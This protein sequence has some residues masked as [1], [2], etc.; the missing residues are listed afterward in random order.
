MSLLSFILSASLINSP[1]ITNIQKIFSSPPNDCMHMSELLQDKLKE[2]N[3]KSKS[4]LSNDCM[5]TVSENSEKKSEKN[6][7]TVFANNSYVV[8]TPHLIITIILDPSEDNNHEISYVVMN[9]SPN[10]KLDP[11]KE[12]NDLKGNCFAT[13]HELQCIMKTNTFSVSISETFNGVG[14]SM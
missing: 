11:A 10:V 14:E 6:C 1:P 4:L 3:I 13:D 2:E 12:T 9:V 7:T 5:I 8:L